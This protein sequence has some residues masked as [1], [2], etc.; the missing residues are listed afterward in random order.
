MKWSPAH[1]VCLT[2]QFSSPSSLAFLLKS[3][4]KGVSLKKL[5]V[6]Q[7]LSVVHLLMKELQ[8][9]GSNAK[10]EVW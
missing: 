9:L 2:T 10:Q 3:A 6:K 7:G 1:T 4:T 5:A 8:V